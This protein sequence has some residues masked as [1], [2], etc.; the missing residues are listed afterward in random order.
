MDGL[1]FSSLIGL[2]VGAI[3]TGFGAVIS[4]LIRRS[5]KKLPSV[6]MSF[7][8]G[9][10]F[11]VVVLDL[12]PEAYKSGGIYTTVIGALAGAL[13][14][15]LLNY[16]LPHYDS[17]PEYGDKFIMQI[18]MSPI[19]RT[20]VLIGAGIAIHNFPEGLAIGSGLQSGAD[21][22][23][24]LAILLMLHNIPEGLAMSI[25]LRIGG[26]KRRACI[27]YAVLAG[28]PTAIG[29]FFGFII[30]KISVVFIGGCLAF[31]GGAMLY[32]TLKEL[33]PESLN[34]YKGALTYFSIFLGIAAGA[35]M[36]YLV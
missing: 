25:P 24:G 27:L 10:M 1:L 13:F 9:I 5:G 32:I 4:I 36:V 22:G 11:S 19:V 2:I 16:L 21:F 23:I 30:G 26:I 31:A 20:G 6:L 14:V 34:I 7:S 12:I 8:G 3:G 33:I 18:R 35:A 29:A 15:V 17:P 28:L